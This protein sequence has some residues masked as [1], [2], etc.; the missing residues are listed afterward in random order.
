[1]RLRLL[2]RVVKGGD[3]ITRRFVDDYEARAIGSSRLPS[4]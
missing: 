1:M 2:I 4:V 3:C